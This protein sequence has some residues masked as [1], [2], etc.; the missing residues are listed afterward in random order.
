MLEALFSDART[1]MIN[2]CK[3]GAQSLAI[4]RQ[5]PRQDLYPKPKPSPTHSPGTL[6]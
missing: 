2:Y 1:P 6:M 3:V 5:N 4:L